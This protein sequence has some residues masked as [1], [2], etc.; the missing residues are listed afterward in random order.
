MTIS[1]ITHPWRSAARPP[2]V[3]H[4]SLLPMAAIARSTCLSDG[5][6]SRPL[7]ISRPPGATAAASS[8]P[9]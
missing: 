7:R 4:N 6:A 2:P 9:S 3:S 8:G 1:T 5:S